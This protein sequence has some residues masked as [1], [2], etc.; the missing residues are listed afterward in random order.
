MRTLPGL[1]RGAFEAAP[2][3]S[4]SRGSVHRGATGTAQGTRQPPSPPKPGSAPCAGAGHLS[5]AE[6]PATSFI[7]E[8]Y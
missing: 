8:S 2:C 1:E 7:R 6:P 3:H 5:Q 4:L